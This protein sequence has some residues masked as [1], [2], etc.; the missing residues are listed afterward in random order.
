MMRLQEL[1]P[2]VVHLPL[3][4]LP[5]AIGADLMGEASDDPWWREAGRRGI[6][7]TALS[8]ALAGITGLIAQE[9]VNVEGESM[10]MLI[11]HRNLNLLLTLTAGAMAFWRARRESPTPGY[12]ALGVAGIVGMT[13]T[14]Y[15][16]GKLVYHHGVGVA[17]AGGQYRD[18]APELVPGELGEFARA[19]G[20]DLVR[21][22]GHLGK[23]V[24]QGKLAP[25][26]RP[27]RK[28][29]RESHAE[30]ES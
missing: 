7:A 15:L 28:W 11:T 19:M 20:T 6:A 3:A 22:A 4:A 26:L 9:E 17:P 25:S 30:V 2:A 10:E 24:A 14:A 29:G 5:F 23:E 8:G 18:D 1:H 13:Y 12:L 16:G 27:R 21:G